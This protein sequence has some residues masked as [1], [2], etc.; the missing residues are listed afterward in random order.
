M[1]F[2][3][4]LITSFFFF[5]VPLGIAALAPF[6]WSRA[7][8]G[9]RP[10]ILLRNLILEILLILIIYYG[11]NFTSTI[12]RS[13]LLAFLLV[14]FT[15]FSGYYL[16]MILTDLRLRSED[17]LLDLGRINGSQWLIIGAIHLFFGFNWA[18]EIFTFRYADIL[19]LI[20]P[21]LYA[22]FGLWA[23][24]K[25]FSKVYITKQGI[26]RF[27]GA[28]KWEQMQGYN[29]GG[30]MDGK[31]RLIIIRANRETSFQI[32]VGLQSQVE[33]IFEARVD[34]QVADSTIRKTIF[35]NW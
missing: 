33:K 3:S 26:S 24:T 14:F 8:K 22:L 18:T 12:P 10:Y 35:Q 30:R 25:F 5:I 31:I 16:D 19:Q 23:F 32:P 11:S 29:W 13:F 9:P 28:I 20:L 34:R 4:D 6:L 15:S 21:P 17:I 1:F 2:N 7:V 27:D